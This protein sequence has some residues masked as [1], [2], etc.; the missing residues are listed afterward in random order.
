VVQLVNMSL[1]HG[2]RYKWNAA[3][4]KVEA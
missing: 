1:K 3:A 4:M 2:R